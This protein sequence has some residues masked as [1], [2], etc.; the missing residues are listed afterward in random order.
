MDPSAALFSVF[1]PYGI[2]IVAVVGGILS[3]IFASAH[4]ARIRELEIRERIAMIE[5]GMVP[6]PEKD[7]AEFE[8]RMHSVERM[9]HSYAG[10]RFRT[11]G[12][13]VI[14]IGL[15]LLLMLTAVGAQR[16]GI[17][18]GGFIV[19]I[20][21]GLLLNSLFHAPPP[22]PRQPPTTPPPVSQS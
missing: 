11:G 9:Q 7:P 5:R 13:M 2:A 17:G 8:R 19:L 21:L 4:R 1:S 18:V 16:V 6:P 14:S 10:A 20:G 12:I 3:G 22:P 15:G